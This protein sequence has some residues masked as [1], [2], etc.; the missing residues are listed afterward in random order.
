MWFT[1]VVCDVFHLRGCCFGLLAVLLLAVIILAKLI[2]FGIY[3][4]GSLQCHW[5]LGVVQA[6]RNVVI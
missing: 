3:D 4:F 1:V 2:W 6:S 5:V